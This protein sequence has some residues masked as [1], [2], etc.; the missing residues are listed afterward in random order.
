MKISPLPLASKTLEKQYTG[1]PNNAIS[2]HALWAQ[3]DATAQLSP[4]FDALLQT[5]KT[6]FRVATALIFVAQKGA[7]A[8]H[9]HAGVNTDDLGC[10]DA[11]S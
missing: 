8:L 10:R 9:M 4:V 1:A 2:L 11:I 3:N 6:R 7:V 5:L